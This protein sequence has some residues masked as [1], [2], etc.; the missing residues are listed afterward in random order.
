MNPFDTAYFNELDQYAMHEEAIGEI[1]DECEAAEDI[2]CV[3]G[4]VELYFTNGVFAQLQNSN[5][6][7]GL[8]LMKHPELARYWIETRTNKTMLSY[9]RDISFDN[10]EF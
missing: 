8:F 10:Q 3:D 1:L 6:E 9:N 5:E 2:S 7:E 4:D